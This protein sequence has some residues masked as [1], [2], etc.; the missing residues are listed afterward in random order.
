MPRQQDADPDERPAR[1]SARARLLVGLP[2]TERRLELAGVSTAVLEGGDGPPLVLLHGPGEFAAGWLPVLPQLVRTHRVIAPDLPGHGAS[3]L[4]NDAAL[5][6]DRVLGWLGELIEVTCPTPPVLVGRIVGG[7]IGARFAIDDSSRLSGLVLVDTLGLTPF[8]PAPRF[9]L[10]MHRFLAAPTASTYDRFMEFCSFDLDGLRD[11][12]DDRWDPFAVYAVELAGNPAVQSAMGSLIGTF[13][14][15]IPPEELARIKIPTTLIWGRHDLATPLQVAE[16]AS[17][18][19]GWPLHVIEHAGD[20]PSLEQ[21]EAFLTALRVALE[22]A[23][24]AG[25]LR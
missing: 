20:D 11:Q 4:S 13:G 14:S 17:A 1:D 3:A 23:T 21:P 22:T 10:A 15:P 12:L 5:D 18:R 19:Y 6:A 2:V 8:D 9:G 25:V 7:A 16:S 24:T